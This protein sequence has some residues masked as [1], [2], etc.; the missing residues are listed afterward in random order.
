MT[1]VSQKLD[2][3]AI[4][5]TQL[6]DKSCVAGFSCGVK[7]IDAWTKSKAAKFHEKG[8]ARVFVARHADSQATL[9][10]YSLSF[11]LQNS[12]KL[13]NQEDRDAWKDG[14]P[15]VYLDY[16]GVIRSH[17]GM[18]LGTLLLMDTLKRANTVFNNV[19]VFG[20]ALRSLNERT[21]L[22]YQKFG[23]GVAPD[24]VSHPLMILP[25]WTVVDLFSSNQV[26]S[27]IDKRLQTPDRP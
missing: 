22:L 16:I 2:P 1:N 25:I 26:H 23:F 11:S 15:L 4:K 14:A 24:E 27:P 10:F 20:V 21:T 9:G 18:G 7:E 19:A 5:I 8:R 17:Q 12:S 3:S 6:K 13:T